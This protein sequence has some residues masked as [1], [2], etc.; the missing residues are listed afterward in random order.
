MVDLSGSV[1]Q[2][3]DTI[4][5][6]ITFT[7]TFGTTTTD[8]LSVSVVAN[9]APTATFSNQSSNLNQNLVHNKY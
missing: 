4:D 7:N 3:G 9:A 8:A 1:T 6:T 5:S 2:S